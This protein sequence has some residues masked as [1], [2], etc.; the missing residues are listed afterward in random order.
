M[1]GEVPK[2]PVYRRGVEP[3][4]QATDDRELVPRYTPLVAVD[5]VKEELPT[6][7]DGIYR[8]GLIIP[9]ISE[10]DFGYQPTSDMYDAKADL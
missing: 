5:V 1:K 4:L 8:K 6:D 7:S 10:L 3:V 2:I 9:V